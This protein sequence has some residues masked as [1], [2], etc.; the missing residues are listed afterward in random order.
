MPGKLYLIPTPLDTSRPLDYSQPEEVGRIIARLRHYVVEELRSARRF[1]S[2]CHRGVVIDDLSFS[3]LNEHTRAEEIESMLAPVDAGF[4][5]GLMSEAG[6]PGVADPGAEL[7]AVAHRRGIEVVPLV[8]ASSIIMS[9]MASVL[10]GQ[11]FTFNGYLP[12]ND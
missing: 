11:T 4:D 9:L 1:I 5:L 3:V 2:S 6:V 10:T 8:G 12:V 7:V